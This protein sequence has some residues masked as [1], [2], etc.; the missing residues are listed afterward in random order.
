MQVDQP[1]GTGS[2]PRSSHPERSTEIM[3]EHPNRTLG[4]Y[5][6][7]TSLYRGLPVMQVIS[8][9]DTSVV[10]GPS[11]RAEMERYAVMADGT[12]GQLHPTL[13]MLLGH[14]IGTDANDQQ[15]LHYGLVTADFFKHPNYNLV[16]PVV[17]AYF[18]REAVDGWF[19]DLGKKTHAETLFM[20]DQGAIITKYFEQN[21]IEEATTHFYRYKLWFAS[22]LAAQGTR[23]RPEGWGPPYTLPELPVE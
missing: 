12:G 8:R 1:A 10:I 2:A 22:L 9:I 5:I 16:V 20:Q 19:I 11:D 3:L 13:A 17:R 6:E 23:L 7:G 15:T 21:L 18:S 4:N 14:T